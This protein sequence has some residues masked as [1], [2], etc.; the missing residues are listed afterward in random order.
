MAKDGQM[1]ETVRGF[2]YLFIYLELQNHCRWWLQPWN[3]KKIHDQ[4]R[5]YI[6]KLRHYFVNKGASSQ[7]YAFSSSHVW[8][9]KLN[10]KAVWWRIDSFELWC[11]RRLLRVPWMARRSS[12]S[13]LNE[14]NPEYS[15]EGWCWSWNSNALATWCEELT[16]WK[17]PWCWQILKAGREGDDREWDG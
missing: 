16:H 17:R 8:M 14:I 4:P 7:S 13:I 12:R 15:L 9:W 5:Q 3:W 2:I 1:M 6:K 11:W 10:H